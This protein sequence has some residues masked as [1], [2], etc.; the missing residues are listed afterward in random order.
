[1]MSF[2]PASESALDDQVA[3]DLTGLAAVASAHYQAGRLADAEEVYRAALAAA[4]DNAA[5]ML[6]LGV[7]AAALGRHQAAIDLFDTVIARKPRYV[8]A[9]YNR[10]LACLTLGRCRAAIDDLSR[11]C[12]LQP[13]HYDAHRALGFL[14]LAEGDKGRALDHFARTYELRRGDDRSNLAA[15][16]LTH[17]TRDKLLHDAEQFRF[18]AGMRDGQHFAA[19]ARAYENIAREFPER[20]EKLSDGQI[21]RLGEDYNRPINL[22]A[23]PEIAGGAINP[24]HDL[25]VLLDGFRTNR[26][27]A[28]YFDDLLTAEA[29]KRLKSFLL[30]STI[31]HDFSHIGGFV[32]SYLED[33]LACPLILQIADEIR[34]VF[35][36]LLARQ[37]LTQAWAFKGLKPASAIDV[38]ADDGAFTV[39]FWITP[40]AANLKPD[41]GGLIVSLIPPPD[42]WGISG[43]DI[44]R[45]GIL[46]I[47]DQAPESRLK[48]PYKENRAVLFQS[49]LFHWSDVPE[50][51]SGYD[52]R[53]INLTFIYGRH[54]IT[55]AQAA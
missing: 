3:A 24:R 2:G 19:L 4:P 12:R 49:R 23:A 43:Y 54:G 33:G 37:S 40:N 13:E 27:G 16:S 39:N 32:A 45:K 51:A 18:L 55:A 46:S 44:D 21:G 38:H 50:F 42:D 15:K 22:R 28:A 31:W 35:A 5:I 7:I 17:A 29:L 25:G 48:V 10:A 9:Y 6:N 52:N 8:S 34:N 41:R 26:A 30:E 36:E 53:R 1:M 47:L 20:L 14:W 11:V